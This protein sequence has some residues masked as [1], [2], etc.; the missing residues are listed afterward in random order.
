[1]PIT[2]KTLFSIATI[3]RCTNRRC[4]PFS[5]RWSSSLNISPKRKDLTQIHANN[6]A[7]VCFY[8]FGNNTMQ[9]DKTLPGKRFYDSTALAFSGPLSVASKSVTCQ[10][11]FFEG[12]PGAFPGPTRPGC[13][14]LVTFFVQAKTKSP[15]AIL[16]S[17]MRT[18]RANARE[19]VRN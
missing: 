9:G 8:D 1:M 19:G 7:N 2:G 10:G 17:Q 15:G 16:N 13:I 3:T 14:S 12:N 6:S 11:A 4:L 5:Y 18:R